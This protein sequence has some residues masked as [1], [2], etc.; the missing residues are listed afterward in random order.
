MEHGIRQPGGLRRRR[1]PA[2][3]KKGC[4]PCRTVSCRNPWKMSSWESGLFRK[5]AMGI[6]P[7]RREFDMA[8]MTAAIE[9]NEKSWKFFAI[10][11]RMCIMVK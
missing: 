5:K 6:R 9:N 2:A 3:N 8:E 7:D 11:G 1:K 4:A 10:M